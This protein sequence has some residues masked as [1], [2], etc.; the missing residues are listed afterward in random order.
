MDFDRAYADY[1]KKEDVAAIE[2]LEKETGTRI[3][4]YYAPPM[5][6]QVPEEQLQKIKDLESKLC[7]RL[8][9]YKNH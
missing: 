9:A 6:A 5:A 3:L 7:V 4:A 8:V 2:A 1:L